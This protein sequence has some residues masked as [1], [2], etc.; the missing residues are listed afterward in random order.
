MACAIDRPFARLLPVFLPDKIGDLVGR[1]VARVRSRRMENGAARPVDGAHVLHGQVHRVPGYRRGIVGIDAQKTQPAPSDS[2]Y[3][4]IVVVSLRDHRF[5]SDVEARDIA[6]ACQYAYPAF[7][8]HL[9][10]RYSV[11]SLS[12]I[13]YPEGYFLSSLSQIG[14][15]GQL[16]V[17][18]HPSFGSPTPASLSEGGFTKVNGFSWRGWREEDME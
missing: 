11:A 7:S 17:S 14:L 13:K 1:H 4:D 10:L 9:P 3:S 18:R 8:S 12:I 15:T 5:D 6:A 16:D 2:Y